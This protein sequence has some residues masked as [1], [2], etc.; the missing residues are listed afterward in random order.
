MAINGYD[1][2]VNTDQPATLDAALRVAG[3]RVDRA[4]ARLLL[5]HALGKPTSWL[6]AHASDAI[7]PAA[8]QRFQQL[9]EGRVAGQPVAYLTGTRGFW[10]LALEV[11][12][13]TLIPR[14]ETELLVE[15][16]LA[17]LPRG[18]AAR[19]ADLG[20][21]SGAI[22]LAIASERPQALVVATDASLGAL[23]VARRNA[24]GNGISNVEFRHGSW[25]GPLADE[26]FNLIVSNPPY[27]PEGDP[28]LQQGDLRFEPPTA[29]SSGSDGL[30]DIREIVANAVAHLDAGG[31]MLLEHGLDQGPSIRELLDA[32]GFV[33]TGTERD[34]EQDLDHRP[35]RIEIE[36]VD[37]A[38]IGKA[39]PV[40][41]AYADASQ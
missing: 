21:G 22:A 4:D 14:P 2:V 19:V 35:E 28:H 23:D 26:R 11:T 7:D 27:I 25:F 18:T 32:A 24:V 15:L 5:A 13:E 9:L 30:D 34:L 40:D 20:T 41:R 38:A 12:P 17:R 1:V 37:D 31:W 39:Q 3:E 6:Y 29:L 36:V 10:S 33:E 16:A 8:M